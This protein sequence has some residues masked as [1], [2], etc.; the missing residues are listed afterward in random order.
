VVE[1]IVVVEVEV[2]LIDVNVVGSG[3]VGKTGSWG[4]TAVYMSVCLRGSLFLWK[5]ENLR[6]RG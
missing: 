4:Q 5:P 2:G 1:G 3:D 6:C